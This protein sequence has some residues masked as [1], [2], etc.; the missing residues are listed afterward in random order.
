[1]T[2]SQR[3][4]VASMVVIAAAT[5]ALA[6]P[7]GRTDAPPTVLAFDNRDFYLCCTLRF[8]REGNATDAN[9]GYPFRDFVLRAGTRV[10][11]TVRRSSPD[12]VLLE[13]KD[14]SRVFRLWMRYGR[15]EMD[16]AGFFAK[17]LLDEDPTA[18]L[19]DASAEIR[20][21][22]RDGRVIVGMSKAE[23]IMARG[24]PP[25]HQTPRLDGSEWIYYVSN[26]IVDSVRFG[27]GR[28]SEIER[29]AAP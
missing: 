3:L 17:V 14:D 22:I 6:G 15:G 24:Y 4:L 21:A 12:A 27:D 23:T 26:G 11:A 20:Q 29:G 8:D 19:K 1:M 9:L 13:P 10:H 25:A 16:I 2:S 7:R 18:S 28:V 5:T